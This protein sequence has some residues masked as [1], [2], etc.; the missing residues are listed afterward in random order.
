[1]KDTGISKGWLEEL[2][3]MLDRYYKFC[4][5]SCDYDCFNCELGV[6][7]SPFDSHSCAIEIVQEIISSDLRNPELK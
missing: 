5:D 1:M 4:T 3:D 7:R 6:L 2:Q